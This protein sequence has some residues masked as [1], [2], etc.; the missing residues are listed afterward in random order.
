M[1]IPWIAVAFGWRWSFAFSGM[2]GFVWLMMWLYM[3]HPLEYHPRLTPGELAL[4]RGGQTTPPH[5][6]RQGMQ[7]WFCVGQELER[8]GHRDRSRAYRPD[9]VVLRLL[10]PAISK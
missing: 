2:L 10:A 1:I 3:Y 4:I 7:R 8:L 5:S 9:L 6:Q